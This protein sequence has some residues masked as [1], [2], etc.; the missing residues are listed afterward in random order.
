MCDHQFKRRKN[1]GNYFIHTVDSRLRKTGDRGKGTIDLPHDVASE[2][3]EL[4]QFLMPP[5][6]NITPYNNELRYDAVTVALT[7]GSYDTTTLAAMINTAS[8]AVLT[9]TFST[10]TYLCTITGP[11]ASVN[12][13]F[14][15]KT[16][17]LAKLLGFAAA[18]ISTPYVGT[19]GAQLNLK[20]AFLKINIMNN[21]GRAKNLLGFPFSYGFDMTLQNDHNG[22]WNVMDNDS[23]LAKQKVSTPEGETKAFQEIEYELRDENGNFMDYLN[24]D[25]IATFKLVLQDQLTY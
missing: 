25:W 10:T 11:A 4:I 14:S 20:K 2:S 6:Y 8:G 1:E 7:V 17:Q 3:I 12:F 23:G 15:S 18:S 16:R 22:L 5:F 21:R 24:M 13:D 9:V 19:S